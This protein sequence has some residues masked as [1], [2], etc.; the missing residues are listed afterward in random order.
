CGNNKANGGTVGVS[1]RIKVVKVIC[2]PYGIYGYVYSTNN[3]VHYISY[4]IGI[5]ALVPGNVNPICSGNAHRIHYWRSGR[6]FISKCSAGPVRYRIAS[7]S[8]FQFNPVL[9]KLVAK[10]YGIYKR[11]PFG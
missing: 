9:Q 4:Y 7:R 2:S 11:K 5:G 10:S 6:N 8:I 1:I 3:F